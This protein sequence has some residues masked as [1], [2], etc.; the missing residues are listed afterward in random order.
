MT[1]RVTAVILSDG[2]SGASRAG[3]KLDR[4]EAL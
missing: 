4:S 1:A 3:Q 2:L